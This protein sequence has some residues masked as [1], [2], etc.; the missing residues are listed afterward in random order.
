MMNSLILP[1]SL[2][3]RG[4]LLAEAGNNLCFIYFSRKPINQRA[5]CDANK[6]NGRCSQAITCDSF[7][8]RCKVSLQIFTYVIYCDYYEQIKDYIE[9]AINS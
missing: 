9:G 6:V 5:R 4:F 8:F 3:F 2:S 1:L 7:F